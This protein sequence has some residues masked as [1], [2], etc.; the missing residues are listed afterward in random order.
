MFFTFQKT[1]RFLVFKD[2]SHRGLVVDENGTLRLGQLGR[3]G[4][5]TV[6]FSQCFWTLLLRFGF[7]SVPRDIRIVFPATVSKAFTLCAPMLGLAQATIRRA[8]ATARG[9]QRSWERCLRFRN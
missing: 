2:N 3:L 6:K 9:I 7:G 1:N 4:G 5:R 8:A